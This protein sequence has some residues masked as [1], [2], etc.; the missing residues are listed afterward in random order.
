MCR[1]RDNNGTK[2][3]LNTLLQGVLL[4]RGHGSVVLCF[5]HICSS[6]CNDRRC[7]RRSSNHAQAPA[8]VQANTDYRRPGR[9]HGSDGE[10]GCPLRDDDSE[11]QLPL[12]LRRY[13]ISADTQHIW[14]I[15]CLEPSTTALPNPLLSLQV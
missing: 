4:A 3:M 15:R 2:F 11:K 8:F 14:A 1:H 13:R 5:I 6:C 7:V 10:S 9:M 12:A